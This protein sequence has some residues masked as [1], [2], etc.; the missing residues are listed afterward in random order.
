LS[1]RLMSSLAI[2]IF[3]FLLSDLGIDYRRIVPYYGTIEIFFID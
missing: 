1:S 3:S 2:I